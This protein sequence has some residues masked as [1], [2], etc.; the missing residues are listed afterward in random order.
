MSEIGVIVRLRWAL[1]VATLRR[2]PWQVVAFVVGLLGAL[3]LVVFA[4]VSGWEWGGSM[5]TSRLSFELTDLMFLRIV[6]ILAGAA[7]T[8]VTGV[9][10]L[11]LVGGGAAMDTSKFALFGIED[12]RLQLGL[13]ISGLCS[14]PAIAGLLALLGWS[15]VFRDMGVMTLLIGIVS[16]PLAIITIV[17]LSRTLISLATTLVTSKR[18]RNALYII[19]VLLFV[20]ICQIPSMLVGPGYGT[21]VSDSFVSLLTMVLFHQ[22]ATIVGWTP[23]G[24]AFAL[25]FDAFVGA[26]GYLFTHLMI[27]AATWIVCF[28]VCT[29]CLRR[30]RLTV[31]RSEAKTSIR[32]IGAFGWMPDSPSGA[33]SARLLTYLRRDPRQIMV[34]ILPIFFV[35]IFAIQARGVSMVVWQSLIWAG[36]M[37]ALMESNGLAYDGGGFAMEVIAGVRGHVDRIGRVRV[38]VAIIVIYMLVLGVVIALIT[39]DWAHPRELF[40]GLVAMAAGSGV[41]FSGLGLAEITSCTLMYPVASLNKPFSSPQGRAVAQGFFPLVYMLGSVVL[42]L[43]TI[44]VAIG[45]GVGDVPR[46]WFAMLIPA[47]LL[48]GCAALAGGVWLG[49]RLLDRRSLDVLRNLDSFASLQR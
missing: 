19:I 7:I 40:A 32:G 23:W 45:L 39:G 3:A 25:P 49:G 27:L 46:P 5:R 10:Q 9:V 44:A 2:S 15:T 34:L 33:I 24:A 48:N 47:S 35:V 6:M 31:G 13:M 36:W 4:T 22:I 17:A 43:P 1:I 21:E 14:I 42:M 26:W 30:E 18:G 37:M 12:R 20:V 41:A 38:Y 8:F 11:M 29:W 16:A 28:A